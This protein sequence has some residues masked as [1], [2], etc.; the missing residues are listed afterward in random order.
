MAA[1]PVDTPAASVTNMQE[2]GSRL[3]RWQERLRSPT[4]L[5]LP[6]DYPRPIPARMVEAVSTFEL[7][8]SS[9]LSLLQLALYLQQDDD[10]AA[11]D[12]T[13]SP[14]TVLLAAFAVL[15][16]RYTGEEDVVVGSSSESSNPLV[17]RMNVKPEE[18]FLDVLHTVQRVAREAAAEEVP[19][20]ALMQAMAGEATTDASAAPALFRVRFFNQTDASDS[21]LRQTLTAATDFTVIV[22]QRTTESLRQLHPAIELQIAY[23]QVLFAAQRI[24]HMVAQ[25]QTVLAAA[26]ATLAR[27]QV[28]LPIEASQQVGRMSIASALD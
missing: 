19:F 26:A 13:A 25:L 24:E 6:T 28:G 11:S 2:L 1:L 16:H 7:S 22:R 21:T 27:A 18:T 4:E 12:S 23:N 5:Q 10:K 17:L 20:G 9:S 14:F 3:T 8:S 15:L